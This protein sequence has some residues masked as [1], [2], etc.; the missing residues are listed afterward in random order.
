MFESL[1][2]GIGVGF[3]VPDGWQSISTQPLLII[4]GTT[5]VGKSTT[6]A[7]LIDQGLNFT[8]LPNRR[9]LSDKLVIST[10]LKT[11]ELEVPISCRIKRLNYARRYREKFPGGMA[12]ILTQLYV[13]PEQVASLLVFDGLRG[14]NEVCYAANMLAKAKFVV[15]DT[16][17]SVRFQ[18]LLNR[19]NIFDQIAK[20]ELE[21]Q[22]LE[23]ALEGIT[24]FTALGVPE[25]SNFFT[26]AEE[27]NLL[28]LIKKGVLSVAEM[29][30]K[31]K[32]FVE[33][34]RN[35]DPVTTRLTLQAIAPERTLVI[36]TT[37]LTPK[38]V[39]QKIISSLKAKPFE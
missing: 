18:R 12:H 11:D 36:D 2:R 10:L 28:A 1:E 3:P 13:D 32:I 16:I 23:I 24:S 4:V 6:I 17:D 9:T 7:T 25:A 27:Q 29:H 31:L 21:K 37:T 26:I 34:R 22:N 35:Y 15:L 20:S 38:Q 19:H 39:A 33:E 5:G 30:D 8:L 14:E